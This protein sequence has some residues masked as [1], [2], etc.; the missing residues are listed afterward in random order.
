MLLEFRITHLKTY[1]TISLIF[2]QIYLSLSGTK[3]SL[4]A[5]LESNPS[6]RIQAP[7]MQCLHLLTYVT[8]E[9]IAETRQHGDEI[10]P[11]EV[12]S[13]IQRVVIRI[14]KQ[15]L[16]SPPQCPHKLYLHLIA[17]SLNV[18][19]NLVVC[20]PNDVLGNIIVSAC[21]PFIFYGLPGFAHS[22]LMQYVTE[23]EVDIPVSSGIDSD[24]SSKVSLSEMSNSFAVIYF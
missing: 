19:Y 16:P 24:V 14:L 13:C 23:A 8:P 9:V 6:Y 20:A 4:I 15:Q 5:T 1:I 21:R 2:F 10:F 22:E 18:I 11:A 17:S 3:G 12:V 7:A